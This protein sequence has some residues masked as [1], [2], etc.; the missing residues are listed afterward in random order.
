MEQTNAEQAASILI[1]AAQGGAKL[2]CSRET[3]EDKVIRRRSRASTEI[4]Q[5]ANARGHDGDGASET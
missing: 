1:K 4:G 2:D 5:T 3:V